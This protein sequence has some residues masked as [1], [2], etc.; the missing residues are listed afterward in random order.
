MNRDRIRIEIDHRLLDVESGATLM[1]ALIAGGEMIRADCGGRGRCGKCV[2]QVD[3]PTPASISAPGETE[4]I[5]LGEEKLNLGLRLACCTHVLGDILVSVPE[6]SRLSAEV[7]PKAPI[8]FPPSARDSAPGKRPSPSGGHGIAVD[9]GTTTIALYLCDLS[10]GTVLGSTSAR[11]LQSL[12]GEDVI[13]RIGAVMTRREGLRRLQVLAA[14]TIDWAATALSHRLQIDPRR[15][16]SA[17]VVGNSTMIHL[18]LGED[19]SSI[20][21]FPYTPRFT[22]AQ[23]RRGDRIGLNFNPDIQVQSFPLISGFLG[24][25]LVAA[26]LAVDFPSLSPGSLL[27]D[28]GTNGEIILKTKEGFAAASCATGPALEGAA[29]RHGMHAVSG[30]IDSVRFNGDTRRLEWRLIQQN[31]QNHQP[32]SGICGSGV[33][34]IIA[35]LLRAGVLLPNGSYNRDFDSP[36]LH[37][38]PG[39]TL[40]FEIVPEAIARGGKAIVL[41]QADVRAVQLAKGALRTGIELLCREHGFERPSRILLAGSFGSSIQTADALRIGMFPEISEA[42]IECVGNAAGRGAILG[43]CHPACF[44]AA[45]EL[46]SCTRVFDLAA[47]PDFQKTFIANLSF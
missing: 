11:N 6:S 15:L 29:I 32:P 36:C 3:R 23:M 22:A 9:L 38:G 42:E 30:A 8:L 35:E 16:E 41:T 46:A 34:S 2:V 25:D 27:V 28:I 13:S 10:A 26:A 33:I 1:E 43:L 44:D 21:V 20:G 19:P 31:P 14:K 17:V 4:R 45:H 47:H 7:L 5:L 12:F 18:L 24:A 39:G 40:A 37:Q